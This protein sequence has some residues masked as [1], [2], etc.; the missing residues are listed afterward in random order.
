MTTPVVLSADMLCMDDVLHIVQHAKVI[1]IAPAGKIA[2]SRKS[3]ELFL[4]LYRKYGSHVRNYAL[5]LHQDKEDAEDLVQN[6]FLKLWEKRLQIHLIGLPENYLF[7]M[8]KNRFYTA[9]QETKR[10]KEIYSNYRI[11]LTDQTNETEETLHYRETKRLLQAAE[12]FLPPREKQAFILKQEGYR[13]KEIAEQMGTTIRT[14]TNQL[15]AAVKK[16]KLFLEA[17]E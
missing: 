8:T 17:D 12:N 2:S 1:P 9:T 16:V 4:D 3:E 6:V 14:T 15:Q 10:K 5:K 7:V 13:I 11:G